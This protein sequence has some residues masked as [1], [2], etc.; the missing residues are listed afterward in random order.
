MADLVD[1]KIPEG[2]LYLTEITGLL[3]YAVFMVIAVIVMLN[4][5]IAMM[6]NTYTN[7]EVIMFIV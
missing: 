4:A 3:L 1:L 6:S 7:V 5:L 2:S